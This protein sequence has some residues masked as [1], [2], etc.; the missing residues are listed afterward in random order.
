MGEA[1]Q[2]FHAENNGITIG[3]STFYSLRPRQVKIQSPHQTCMCIYHEN[4]NLAL[5][6]SPSLNNLLSLGSVGAAKYFSF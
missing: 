4:F 3:K 6:V 1:F 5:E 2:L